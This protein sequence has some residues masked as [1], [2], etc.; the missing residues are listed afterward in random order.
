[1][2][3]YAKVSQILKLFPLLDPLGRDVEGFL[4]NLEIN[5]DRLILSIMLEEWLE[6]FHNL[7]CVFSGE[8]AAFCGRKMNCKTTKSLASEWLMKF[9]DFKFWQSYLLCF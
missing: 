5:F 3:V 1:M 2:A 6:F 8:I 4:A 7:A 9:A